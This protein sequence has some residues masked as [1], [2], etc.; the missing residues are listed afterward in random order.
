MPNLLKNCTVS[1]H[2]V[3]TLESHAK[4]AKHRKRLSKPD[5][6]TISFSS[7]SK[8]SQSA[9]I[10]ILKQTSI[11]DVHAKQLATKVWIIWWIDV[12][13]SN[14]SFNSVSNK[15]NIFCKISPD[16]KIVENFSCGKTKCTYVVCFGLAPY[17]KG[18]LNKSLRNVEHIV[19]L[20]DE[21]FNKTSKRGQMNMRVCYWDNDHNYVA[22][23]YY[24]SEFMDKA[25]VKDVFESFSACLSGISES[26][27]FP[28]FSDGPNVNLSF[29]E[30]L[31]EE[32]NEKE[33][34]QEWEKLA[35]IRTCG[36]HTLNNSEKHSEKASGWNVKTLLISLHRILDESPSTRA[37][38]EALTQATSSD[39]PLQFGLKRRG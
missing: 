18:R 29:L 24:Y 8:I 2:G 4:S 37:D 12:I 36:L 25:S 26:K 5:G 32:R 38:Y 7:S 10:S 6:S 9:E 28:V 3:K 21:S 22:T 35:H 11:V 19:A 16:S 17:F 31:E 39:Y 14:F 20:F 34:S 23:H 13:L 30:L 27:L 1:G 33:L 15:S